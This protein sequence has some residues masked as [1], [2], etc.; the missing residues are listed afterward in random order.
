M[1]VRA[2]SRQLGRSPVQVGTYADAYAY[3]HYPL[4]DAGINDLSNCLDTLNKRQG[5]RWASGGLLDLTR[6]WDT[7]TPDSVYR[8]GWALPF[9]AQYQWGN[10]VISPPG[11]GVAFPGCPW[12]VGEE[13]VDLDS[14][15]A[16][17]INR[18]RPG[19][20]AVD[21]GVTIGEMRDA[22][23]LL[24]KR[25]RELRDLGDLYL[26]IQF[27][28]RPFLRDLFGFFEQMYALD[29]NLERFQK[30]FGRK[31]RRKGR[32]ESISE[33]LGT[34]SFTPTFTPGWGTAL[35]SSSGIRSQTCSKTIWF[36]GEFEFPALRDHRWSPLSETTRRLFG[37]RLT[38]D[39]VWNLIPWTWL[40]DWAWNVGDAI[41]NYTA[42]S[43]DKMSINYAYLMGTYQY[44]TNDSASGH[45]VT[46]SPQKTFDVSPS[47]FSGYS[48]KLR[49]VADPYA[50]RY[51]AEEL[52]AY[53][54]SI[55]AALGL[56]RS[57][58]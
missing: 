51:T 6:H 17:S 23:K 58:L 36:S 56:S 52:D 35:K 28:W 31:L 14:Y 39:V 20:P 49:V 11:S 1:T 24:F 32:V 42:L 18:F 37:L 13:D 5:R 57:K 2:R 26:K 9:A 48:R 43:V 7:I 41:A 21:L 30:Q 45:V 40:I 27:G 29:R 19:K 53:R 44:S 38:P 8:D 4:Y 50:L 22:P 3:V 46:W 47:S 54:L 10:T 12:T 33:D 34:S 55:L 16:E 25:L 15:G